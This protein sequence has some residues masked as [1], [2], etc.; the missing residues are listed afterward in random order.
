MPS[1]A[2]NSLSGFCCINAAEVRDGR[3]GKIPAAGRVLGIGG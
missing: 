1:V 3:P 2:F